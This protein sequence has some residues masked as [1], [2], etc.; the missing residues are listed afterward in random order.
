M[1]QLHLEGVIFAAVLSC[2]HETITEECPK[3]EYAKQQKITSDPKQNYFKRRP[4]LVNQTA[5]KKL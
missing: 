1:A 5:G 3:G 4:S 2:G